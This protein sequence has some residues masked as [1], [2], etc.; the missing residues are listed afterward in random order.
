MEV[1]AD[2]VVEDANLTFYGGLGISF[3][4]YIGIN[5]TF[6]NS[7]A[8]KYD[9]FYAKAVQVIP[10]EG[11]VETI[12]NAVAYSSAITIFEHPVMA[13]SMTENVTITLYA[14]LDGVTYV[15]Q[16]VSGSVESL[17]LSKL[18]TY[19]AAGYTTYCTA[20][21]DMLN[22]GAEVQENQ[23]HNTDSMPSAGEYA[24]YG[25]ATTPELTAENTTTG[26]GFAPA[27]VSISMQA[28]V[29]FNATYLNSNLGT[30]TVKAYVD[31]EEV[32]VLYNTDYAGITIARIAVA[33]SKLRSNYTIAV[34][35]A[36]GNVVSQVF[37]G[38]VE[39]LAKAHLGTVNNDL[40]IAMMR[41]GDSV[42]AIG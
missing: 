24:S 15:G 14:E 27:R 28:K 41:Y 37:E 22:Y 33:A 31:G 26:T 25:T 8:S 42:S 30:G 16:T 9:K 34:Y 20:L 12:C 11:E 10:G 5:A 32:A 38:S 1:N 35:D 4:D 2:F 17:A 19:S 7:T 21:V 18:A 29:E 36:D 3:Q 6:L 13:W 40:V 39:S 23:S